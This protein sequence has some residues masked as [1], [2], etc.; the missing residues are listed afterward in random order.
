MY[1]VKNVVEKAQRAK[2]VGKSM[3][4]AGKDEARIAAARLALI[5][6]AEKQYHQSRC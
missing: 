1:V 4:Y 5:Q 2:E 3:E 6:G